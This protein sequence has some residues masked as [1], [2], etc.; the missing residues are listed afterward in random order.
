MKDPSEQPSYEEREI[1]CPKLGGPVNFSYC[2]AEN[3]GK[4]CS[5]TI[6]CWSP[7]FDVI[8]YYRAVF[9]EEEFEECFCQTQCSKMETLLDLIT[10]ARKVTEELKDKEDTSD[11][12]STPEHPDK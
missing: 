7:Y 11:D 9:T 2:R 1:R 4:P 8:A 10:R 5:R 3:T 6:N 12:P